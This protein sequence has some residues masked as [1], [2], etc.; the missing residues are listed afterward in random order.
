MHKKNKK[1]LFILMIFIYIIS[2]SKIVFG[3]EFD[4]EA[5]IANRQYGG[6]EAGV[7]SLYA[8]GNAI[9]GILQYV[10]AGVAV[11]ATLIL[12]M[13]YMYTSPDEKAEVKKK[14]IPYVIGGVMIFGATSLVRIVSIFVTEIIA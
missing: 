7:D 3:G 5:I 6:G 8:I 11:I 12:A 9:L 2:I 10:G 1:I 13:K 4:P 14:L